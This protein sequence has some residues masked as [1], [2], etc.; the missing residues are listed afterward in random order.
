[1]Q[2]P[3]KRRQKEKKNKCKTKQNKNNDNNKNCTQ[4]VHMLFIVH[5]ANVA[6]L[7]TEESTGSSCNDN[8]SAANFPLCGKLSA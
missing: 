5:R 4:Y 7:G 6:W 8:F 2:V 1:M 3:K